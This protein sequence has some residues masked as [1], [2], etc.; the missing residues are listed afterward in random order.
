MLS[1]QPFNFFKRFAERHG[2][3][4]ILCP[5]ARL[6]PPEPPFKFPGDHITAKRKIHG[7]HPVSL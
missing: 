3:M 2:P 5:A 1:P 6:I 7:H 4:L